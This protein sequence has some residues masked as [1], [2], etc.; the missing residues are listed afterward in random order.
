M[1][2]NGG[3]LWKSILVTAQFFPLRVILALLEKVTQ[4]PLHRLYSSE[5]GKVAF[6][7]TCKAA[8]EITVDYELKLTARRA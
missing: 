3:R 6:I 8:R 7:A 1:T 2:D 4:E 5:G